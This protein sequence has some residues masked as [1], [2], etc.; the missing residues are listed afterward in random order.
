MGTFECCKRSNDLDI[1]SPNQIK[2]INDIHFP[3]SEFE[4]T[5]KEQ[6]LV[7]ITIKE[8]I[9]R[10][11]LFNIEEYSYDD[12][13]PLI[14]IYNDNTLIDSLIYHISD[15][16]DESNEESDKYIFDY[17]KSYTFNKDKLCSCIK[18]VLKNEKNNV[19]IGYS[20]SY[21]ISLFA[22]NK[23]RNI[24]VNINKCFERLFVIDITIK[25]RCKE[26]FIN[27]GIL[28]DLD[29]DENDYQ[30]N[31]T[32]MVHFFYYSINKEYDVISPMKFIEDNKNS[33]DIN[34]AKKI[35][36]EMNTLK[37]KEN[38]YLCYEIFL[39][40]IDTMKNSTTSI[41]IFD[42]DETFSNYLF[43]YSYFYIHNVLSFI[44]YSVNNS[45]DEKTIIQC[46]NILI[47]ILNH[48]EGKILYIIEDIIHILNQCIDK[49]NSYAFSIKIIQ[50]I[51]LIQSKLKENTSSIISI[52]Y[53][54]MLIKL[55]TI[56]NNTNELSSSALTQS[57]IINEEL[58]YQ[59]VLQIVSL[60]TK[61]SS[62]PLLIHKS[63][64]LM[65]IMIRYIT[66]IDIKTIDRF[67]MIMN[68]YHM[69][70]SRDIEKNINK[71]YISLISSLY[72]KSKKINE[73]HMIKLINSFFEI[74][75]KEERNGYSSK[76][77][78]CYSIHIDIVKIIESIQNKEKISDNIYKECIIILK[79]I[80]ERISDSG[81]DIIT[82]INTISNIPN[83]D[84]SENIISMIKLLS[85]IK[86]ES[87]SNELSSLKSLSSDLII[88][89]KSKEL[90]LI[91]QITTM[92][93]EYIN[94][95]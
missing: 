68:L 91:E 92:L 69:N 67:S 6:F 1:P 35:L 48:I 15:S 78:E 80:S 43:D 56:L 61:Q 41:D 85:N 47:D 22:D 76:I 29:N 77:E 18:F 33:F 49:M 86:K 19:L 75:S 12:F 83:E 31:E 89:L 24:S 90:P 94:N 55:I 54:T 37:I 73:S 64:F 51:P 16:D 14:E 10:N 39:Y 11:H 17:K 20:E 27:E 52:E 3:Y 70:Y 30:D 7:D 36:S 95:I 62:F 4:S 84:I 59:I 25:V 38:Y 93:N 58:S 72:F 60:M 2:N 88:Y 63:F 57:L 5:I 21:P 53:L 34:K 46:S 66:K 71:A 23:N 50:N 44:F 74:D 81:L 26:T 82:E 8:L 40:M 13:V 79:K 65:N 9:Q 42:N 28:G 45:N 32:N 87:F